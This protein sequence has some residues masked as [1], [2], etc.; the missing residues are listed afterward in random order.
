MIFFPEPDTTS[1]F[2]EV[3][4][5]WDVLCYC[6]CWTTR[7]DVWSTYH[8]GEKSIV[9]YVSL[10]NQMC[11]TSCVMINAVNILE[12]H[13]LLVWYCEDNI[14]ICYPTLF[15]FQCVLADK[16]NYIVAV[17][18]N[19]AA[20]RTLSKY[21]EKIHKDGCGMIVSNFQKNNGQIYANKQTSCEIDF[22]VH[23]S[24]YILY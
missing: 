9:W 10:Y 13:T 20:V 12:E 16:D 4:S 15:V 24:L 17:I 6:V 1:W 21:R 19:T 2:S 8:Q 3:H 11:T 18:K 23:T 5:R 14:W 7:H 22:E